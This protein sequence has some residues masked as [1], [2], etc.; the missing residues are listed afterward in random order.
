MDNKHATKINVL[1]LLGRL[2]YIEGIESDVVHCPINMKPINV[3]E[4]ALEGESW[5]EEGMALCY[6]ERKRYRAVVVLVVLLVER[7]ERAQIWKV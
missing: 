5:E 3:L 7:G 2:R 6:I 1:T 4:L